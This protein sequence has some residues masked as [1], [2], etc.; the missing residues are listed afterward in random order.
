[1]QAGSERILTTHVGSMPRGQAVVDLLAR[2]EGGEPY[3]AAAFDRVMADA[4]RDVVARQRAWN[5]P[6]WWPIGL[7][8]ALAVALLLVGLRQLRQ[9]ERTNARGEL[10]A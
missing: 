6:V 1:M 7:L 5:Q 4:V 3:D 2:K 10:V 8:L 9:R